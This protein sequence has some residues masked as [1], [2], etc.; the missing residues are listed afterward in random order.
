MDVKEKTTGL[1][2]EFRKFI[3]RGN[4]MDLAVGVIIGGAFQSIVNSL[5]NDIIMPFV[6]I[7][8]GENT[9]AALCFSV[10]GAEILLGNFVQAVLNFLIMAA[11]IFAMVKAVNRFH[12]KQ[13]PPPAA[14]APE[15]V[16]LTEIRDL[17]K[18]Q[19]NV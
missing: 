8:I 15:V 11:V 5:V 13:T 6:G 18:E 3:A 1:M 7:F 16:L 19:D 4:V 14:P 10:G 2:A 17:L 9:F 12:K